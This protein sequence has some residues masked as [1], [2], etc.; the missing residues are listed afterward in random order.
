[1]TI[2]GS[3]I[4]SG[5]LTG[6][7]LKGCEIS[8]IILIMALLVL[9]TRATPARVIPPQGLG[10]FGRSVGMKEFFEKIHF[11]SN[12]GFLVEVHAFFAF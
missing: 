4:S 11:D 1:M 6:G 2:P 10:G 9:L 5:P 3:A 8:A 7:I 12:H